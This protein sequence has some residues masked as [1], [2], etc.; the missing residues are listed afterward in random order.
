MILLYEYG[1]SE[2]SS[3]PSQ[4]SKAKIFA[5][6]VNVRKPLTILQIASSDML[7]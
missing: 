7:D 5:K 4:T 1:D 3:E 2:F 6:I